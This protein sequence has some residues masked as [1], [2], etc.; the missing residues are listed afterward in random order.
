M[1][2]QCGKIAQSCGEKQ[3]DGRKAL[4]GQIVFRGVLFLLR[5]AQVVESVEIE[6]IDELLRNMSQNQEGSPEDSGSQIH[7]GADE[8]IGIQQT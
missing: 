1:P 5:I 4:G 2:F 6:A 8:I 3:S 7:K